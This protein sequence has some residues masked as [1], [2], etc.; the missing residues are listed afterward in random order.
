MDKQLPMLYG[1]AAIG[2]LLGI[3]LTVEK[4]NEAL[5]ELLVKRSPTCYET[6]R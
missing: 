3:V 1:L 5:F 6:P 4:R 2:L